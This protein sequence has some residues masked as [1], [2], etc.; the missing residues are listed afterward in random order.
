[1]R[2]QF[3]FAP[4]C[5][6]R[7]SRCS[8]CPLWLGAFS[9]LAQSASA[10]PRQNMR[11]ASIAAFGQPAF[12]I[13]SGHAAGS[14]GRDRLTIVTV[15]H[16]A[17]SEDSFFARQRSLGRR[18]ANIALFVQFQLAGQEVGIRRVTDCEED[19]GVESSSTPPSIVLSRR[20]PVTP[21]RSLP[22]TSANVRFHFIS[23]LGF[24]S[25]RCCMI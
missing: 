24:S 6:A 11:H 16:V 12:G 9:R 17:G 8:R 10:S 22:T 4:F 3:V 13:Q 5:Q 20:T 15:G 21:S 2:T 23:I 25:A 19:A 7:F 18:P 14:S 1:M